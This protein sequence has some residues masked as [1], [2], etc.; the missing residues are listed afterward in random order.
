MGSSVSHVNLLRPLD[1]STLCISQD[2][3]FRNVYAVDL[4][5]DSIPSDMWC[6][7]FEWKWRSS[8]AF[9]DRKLLLMKDKLRLVS[10]TDEF[11]EK[12]DWI[13]QIVDET[14]KAVDESRDQIE[15]EKE[16]TRLLTARHLEQDN[17]SVQMTRELL[18][19]RLVSQRS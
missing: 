4:Q 15:T 18:A 1:L 12:L 17:L 3:R 16:I 10:S 9:W 14:N 8:K 6:E 13:K 7:T 5:L 2:S 19:Q 11:D